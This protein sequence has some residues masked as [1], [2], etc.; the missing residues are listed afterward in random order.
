[1][2]IGL[3]GSG[4]VSAELMRHGRKGG[5]STRTWRRWPAHRTWSATASFRNT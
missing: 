4:A 2:E 5:R 1:M 3:Q